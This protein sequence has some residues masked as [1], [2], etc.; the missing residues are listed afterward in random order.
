MKLVF[1]FSLLLFPLLCACSTA[2]PEQQAAEAAKAYYERLA[3]GSTVDFLE[4]K[5]DIDSLPTALCEQLVAVHQKYLA[6]VKRKHGGI[7]DVRISPNIGRR[8][9]TLQLTYA[10]LMLCF[11]DSTQ[12]E[13]VV[14]MVEANGE[15]KM[16]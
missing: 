14:P 4:G 3:A 12:E 7:Q 2:T 11:A 6:D 9:T 1:H 13:V 8:D 16:K 5:A 10:F 15:W